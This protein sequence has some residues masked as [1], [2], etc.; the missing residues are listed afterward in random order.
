[1]ELSQ[2][3]QSVRSSPTLA[4]TAKARALRDAGVDVISFAAGEPDFNTP[5]PICDAAIEAIARGETKY[6][7]SAG[8]PELR[9][10]IARTVVS[11]TNSKVEPAQVVLSCGAK[12][13]VYN[14]CQAVLN[15]GDECILLAPFWMTYQ[16]QV[17]LTGATPV[18]VQGWADTGFVPSIEDVRAAI[19]PRTRAL[20]INSPSNPT[21]AVLPRAFLKEVA[22]LALKHDLWLISD[23]IYDQLVYDGASHESIYGLGEEVRNRTIYING[24]SKTYAMTGWRLGYAVAPKAVATAMS[25]LQDQVTSNPTSFAQFGAMAALELPAEDVA[26]M[27]DEFD[28]RRRLIVGGLND[29]PG[30]TCPTPGGAFYAFPD[31]RPLLGGVFA[32]DAALAEYLLEEAHVAVVPG[33]VFNGAGHLRLSYATNQDNIREGLARIHRA[34]SKVR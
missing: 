24:F 12:H 6:T 16:D 3:I 29:V 21:G 5:A 33:S 9:Q 11:R 17:V 27:R 14:A 28:A 4:I 2:R 7:A 18:I 22:A 30:F 19:T 26:A 13:S 20:I 25:N 23:E 32:D 31:V 1:M 34:I 10:A 8:L 15:P